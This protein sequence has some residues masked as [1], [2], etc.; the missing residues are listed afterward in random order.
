MQ[1]IYH[2]ISPIIQFESTLQLGQRKFNECVCSAAKLLACYKHTLNNIWKWLCVCDT[3]LPGADA[4]WQQWP[5]LPAWLGIG[6]RFV[7]TGGVTGLS[8]S[9]IFTGL[10]LEPDATCQ[11]QMGKTDGKMGHFLKQVQFTG[12]NQ[13]TLALVFYKKK[14]K[15]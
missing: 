3:W 14:K 2:N 4:A 11:I 9:A 8:V 12:A 5:A 6:G 1:Y 13:I 7:A 10:L 15:E